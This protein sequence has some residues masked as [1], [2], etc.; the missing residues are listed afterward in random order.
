[1][2]DEN[3]YVQCSGTKPEKKKNKRKELGKLWL[4]ICPPN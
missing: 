3:V 1:M 4:I 2:F